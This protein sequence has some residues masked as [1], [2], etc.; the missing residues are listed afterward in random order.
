MTILARQCGIEVELDDEAVQSLVPPALEDWSPAEEVLADAFIKQM[1]AYD[2][3]KTELMAK[4]EANDEVLRFVGV[5]DVETN[6]SSLRQPAPT[7]IPPVRVARSARRRICAFSTGDIGLF[8]LWL[9][10]AAVK[11]LG[12]N[13]HGV[14]GR[15]ADVI[16]TPCVARA[17]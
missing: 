7:R 11:N 9:S 8:S 10:R 16:Q 4:A 6:R 17:C 12:G 2:E 15:Y 1:E 14:A 3:E 13:R 5:V